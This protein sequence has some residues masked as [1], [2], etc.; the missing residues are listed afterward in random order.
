MSQDFEQGEAPLTSD[1]YLVIWRFVRY[2]TPYE[3]L[4]HSV[5]HKSSLEQSMEPLFAQLLPQIMADALKGEI[6]LNAN[7]DW[8]QPD[9]Q[10]IPN[11]SQYM[12]ERYGANPQNLEPLTKVFHIMQRRAT[13]AKGWDANELLL[14]L[15]AQDPSNQSPEKFFATVSIEELNA[16]D[17]KVEANGKTYTLN[18]YLSEV[19][20]Y[21][22]P[23]SFQMDGNT[24]GLASLGEA[25]GSKDFVLQGR[26]AELE[27]FENGP[28][29]S[30]YLYSPQDSATAMSLQGEFAVQADSGSYLTSGE[31][32]INVKVN[33]KADRLEFAWS[34]QHMYHWYLLY[35]RED[36]AYFTNLG[37]VCTFREAAGKISGFT[38]KTHDGYTIEATAL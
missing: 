32:Q 33:S 3:V 1:E 24:V 17:Y 2:A 15:V 20:A 19:I 30:T 11:L 23:I 26:W 27:W 10:K 4:D 18:E 37:D 14:E 8:E 12:A 34:N 21:A 36:G 22:Y 6:A 9:F 35:P 7:R 5:E 25:F 16:K 31:N 28:N 13:A 38:I 29:L